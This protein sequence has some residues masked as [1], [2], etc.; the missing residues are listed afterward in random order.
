MWGRPG[1]LG[2][3]LAPPMLQKTHISDLAWSG[4]GAPPPG[5]LR[6][7]VGSRQV[8]CQE[9]EI[10]KQ[11]GLLDSSCFRLVGLVWGNSLI[12]ADNK[13]FW[14]IV[15]SANWKPNMTSLASLVGSG[16]RGAVAQG[17]HRFSVPLPRPHLVMWWWMVQPALLRCNHVAVVEEAEL[18][19]WTL[20]CS[21][22]LSAFYPRF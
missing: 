14:E 19:H 22:L 13:E 17:L 10:R 11:N 4:V 5:R 8:R 18:I 7:T 6:Q 12:N 2:S 15:I 16:G 1:L 21:Q 3:T 9:P 20:S